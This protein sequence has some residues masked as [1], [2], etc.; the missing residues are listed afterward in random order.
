MRTLKFTTS[1]KNQTNFAVAVRK[2]VNDYF[3]ENGIAPTANI[4]MVLQTLVM[5][6]LYI[7]PFILILTVP[8]NIW[9]ALGLV[10]IMGLGTAGIGMSVMHDAVHGSY[11]RKEWVNKMFGST[12]YLL[13]SNVFNWT[14]AQ[15]T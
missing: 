4:Y 5:L 1:D 13:G 3:R 12:M 6:S 2:N 14:P 10:I 11:S 15:A 9:I 7:V 8:M